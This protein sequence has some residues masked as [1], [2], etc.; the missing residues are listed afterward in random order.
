MIALWGV[1]PLSQAGVRLGLQAVEALGSQIGDGN[2]QCEYK[3][4]TAEAIVAQCENEEG[5]D[6]GLYMLQNGYVGVDRSV[7]YGSVLEEAYLQ[8]QSSAVQS[9]VGVWGGFDRDAAGASDLKSMLIMGSVLLLT[10]ALAFGTLT[11]FIM[12]GFRSV[13][14]AQTANT[15]MISRERALK[16]KEREIFAMMLDSEIKANKSKIEAYI[17]VYDEMLKALKNT[18]KP[19]PYKKAGDLVQAQPAL[20]RAVFDHNTDKL[21]ILGERLSSEVVHFYARI[22][23]KPDYINLEPETPLD[24]ATEIV[25][26]ALHNG[27]RLSKLAGRLIDSFGHGGHAPA[28]D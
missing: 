10:L 12:R 24:E 2:I 17:V 14:H 16:D 18:D 5:L 22:K 23:T 1:E 20:D 27:Q 7:I 21:D 6:L 11:Y 28:E 15:D 26:K 3:T 4:R 25:E 9:G 19:P 13:I 8:A